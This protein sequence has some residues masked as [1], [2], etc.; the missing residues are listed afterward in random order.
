MIGQSVAARRLAQKGINCVDLQRIA[1]AGKVK[2]FCFDKTGTL[3]NS[4]LEFIGVAELNDLGTL[5]TDLS[6]VLRVESIF[7][8]HC[9][10]S[11]SLC[12]GKIVGNF[13]D[14]EIFRV[15]N[16]KLDPNDNNII[17]PNHPGINNFKIVKRFEFLHTN[18]YMSVFCQDIVSQR[19][20][21]FLKGN[22]K[23]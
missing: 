22:F 17:T 7:G 11:L 5:K 9:C 6:K 3:T 14:T 20:F 10:H 16:S 18:M 15:I 12:E 21:M 19:S 2:T 1:L 23:H 8:M 4:G 13:V